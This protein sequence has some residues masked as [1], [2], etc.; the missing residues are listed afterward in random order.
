MIQIQSFVFSPFAENTYVLYDDTQEAVII[1]PGCNS[2]QEHQTLTDFIEENQL[3]VVKLLNTHCHLDH[4]FGNQFVKDTYGVDLYIHEKDLPI[5]QSAKMAAQ[6]YGVK[7]FVASEADH[8]LEE[9]DQVSFGDSELEVI[10]VPGHAPGHIAFVSQA[11]KF[12]ISG[13]VLF[14]MGIGRYDLP[15]CN[16]D[17]LMK[18]IREKLL[19]LGDDF[20]IYPGHGP[21][22]QIGF[23][24]ANNPFLN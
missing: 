9:G 14:Q 16:Y 18:S 22:T 2:P 21:S 12:A 20:E 6:M 1:D 3:K 24:K 15:G 5:L 10:F 11:Q 7:P 23:E 4:V 8:F 19:Q 13:D 17:D